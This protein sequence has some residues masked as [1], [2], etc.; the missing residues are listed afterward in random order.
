M[1]LGIDVSKKTIDCCLIKEDSKRQKQFKNEQGGFEKLKQW[2]DDNHATSELNAVVK[3]Q[4]HITNN[5][6]YISKTI[7]KS[8]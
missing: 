6:L 3:Q 7:T 5:W 4:G 2:L 8:A 1:Y